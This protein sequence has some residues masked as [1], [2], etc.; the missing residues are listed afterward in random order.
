MLASAIRI[1]VIDERIALMT[2]RPDDTKIMKAG[3]R[4]TEGKRSGELRDTALTVGI[5]Y[6]AGDS[7]SLSA[8]VIRAMLFSRGC[9]PGMVCAACN[10]SSSI[11]RA[12][13]GFPLLLNTSALIWK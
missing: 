6:F 2:E 10:A 9:F 5:S 4:R 12:W 13:A 1:V 7:V 3:V 11:R 8:P